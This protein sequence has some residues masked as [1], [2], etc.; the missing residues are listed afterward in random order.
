M[1]QKLNYLFKVIAALDLFAGLDGAYN[2]SDGDHDD[3]DILG[4]LVSATKVIHSSQHGGDQATLKLWK[5]N[6]LF[7]L[8]VIFLSTRIRLLP[9]I[10]FMVLS[11]KYF[12]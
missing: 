12:I 11:F 7:Q 9:K 2:D 5:G 6:V 8:I 10:Y 3:R 1:E 4:Q